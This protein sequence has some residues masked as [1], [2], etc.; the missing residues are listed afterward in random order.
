MTVD[1]TELVYACSEQIRVG[2]R[3]VSDP[4]GNQTEHN[5]SLHY[6]FER[7]PKGARH[8]KRAEI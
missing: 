3:A 1:V 5:A 8:D 6:Y 4:S 2:M 7:L